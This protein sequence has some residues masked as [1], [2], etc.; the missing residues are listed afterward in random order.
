LTFRATRKFIDYHAQI[1]SRGGRIWVL[2]DLKLAIC[3]LIAERD[4]EQFHSP[5]NLALTLSV[6]VAEVGEHF[7]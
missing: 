4:Q 2:E 1:Y 7:Q 3:T 5:K 6:E